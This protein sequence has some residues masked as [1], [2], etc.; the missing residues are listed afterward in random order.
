VIPVPADEIVR[1]DQKTTNA[2]FAYSRVDGIQLTT[3]HERSEIPVLVAGRK[4]P[5]RSL[6][7]NPVY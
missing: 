7:A 1:A 5:K 2:G 6:E 4:A 3:R